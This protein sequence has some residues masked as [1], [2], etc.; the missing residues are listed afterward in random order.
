[1]DAGRV[2]AVT[3]FSNVKF[4]KKIKSSY[5]YNIVSVYVYFVSM[6]ICK[7]KVNEHGPV[8]MAEFWMIVK[9]VV[10]MST[11]I[12]QCYYHQITC[13]IYEKMKH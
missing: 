11:I 9:R 13:I 8:W 5:C 3:D 6:C 1:M 4:V 7:I 2:L 12:F 10:I